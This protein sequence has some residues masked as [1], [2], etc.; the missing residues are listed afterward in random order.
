MS[1][2][3]SK[4]FNKL[5]SEE[6]PKKDSSEIFAKIISMANRNIQNNVNI[7]KD[8]D[9]R[10]KMFQ[11]LSIPKLENQVVSNIFSKI[12]TIAEVS[13]NFKKAAFFTTNE[14]IEDLQKLI[15]NLDQNQK[16]SWEFFFDEVEMSNRTALS[17]L[18]SQKIK[19]RFDYKLLQPE[20]L[21]ND[22]NMIIVL[23]PDEYSHRLA[24]EA[25]RKGKTAVSTMTVQGNT[26]NGRHYHAE[27]IDQVLFLLPNIL[28]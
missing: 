27:S 12:K 7:E 17:Q 14:S 19:L 15:K 22:Y 21:V 20:T 2:F 5:K 28:K 1:S 18:F 9:Y 24:I 6:Q 10:T 16:Y 8:A 26:S 11:K 3:Q 25:V 4:I 13:V 23:S